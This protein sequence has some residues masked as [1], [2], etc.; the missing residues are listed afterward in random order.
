[1]DFIGE[2]HRRVRKIKSVESGEVIIPK[3]P[4][5]TLFKVRLYSLIKVWKGERTRVGFG[6]TEDEAKIL[7]KSLV[8]KM[9]RLPDADEGGAPL[10]EITLTEIRKED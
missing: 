5:G 8:K 9:E 6:L 10:F 1:M 3:V 2:F 7:A 4:Q